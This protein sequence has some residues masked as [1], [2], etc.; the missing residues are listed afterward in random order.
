MDEVQN[1]TNEYL[2]LNAHKR[3]TSLAISRLLLQ[4]ASA[5]ERT[6]LY[7]TLGYPFT[8]R[9]VLGQPSCQDIL[10]GIFP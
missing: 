4:H 3:L 1:R 5:K 8:K 10:V 7:R 9:S 2:A 6:R